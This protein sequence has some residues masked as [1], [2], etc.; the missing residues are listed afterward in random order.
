LYG[1]DGADSLEG[2]SGFDNLYGGAGG[3]RFVF[4]SPYD[5]YKYIADFNAS[6][7]D[8]FVF[9]SAKFGGLT[10]DSVASHFFAGAGFAGFVVEGPY[11]A[12]DT[13]NGNLWYNSPAGPTL[14]AQT[15]LSNLSSSNLYFW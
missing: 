1:Q 14:I 2:G 7:W 12:F 13:T 6:E 9:T 4:D 5:G 3:D 8:A 11:F 10:T 15:T